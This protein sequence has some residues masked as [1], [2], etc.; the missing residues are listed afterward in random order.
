VAVIRD[1][2]I[3]IRMV[4][5]T[6]VPKEDMAVTRVAQFTDITP[7]TVYTLEIDSDGGL[8]RIQVA[9]DGETVDKNLLRRVPIASL[10]ALAIR[11]VWDREGRPD[12]DE[13]DRLV[14]LGRNRAEISALYPEMPL[15]SLGRYLARAHQKEKLNG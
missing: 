13:V 10:R 15:S 4:S 12:Q 14:A 9:L 2:P 1:R 3:P 11:Q 5:A 8:V 6:E 7:G